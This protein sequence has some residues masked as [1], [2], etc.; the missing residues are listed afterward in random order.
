[1]SVNAINS[2]TTASTNSTRNTSGVLGKDEFL[3]LL[4]T[5]LRY[6]DPLNPTDNTEYVSQLAEFSALEQMSNM[7]SGISSMQALSMNGKWVTATV[8]DSSSGEETEIEGVVDS[9][10]VKNGQAT[11]IVNG[12]EVELENVTNVQDYNRASVSNLSS[13]INKT[14]EGYIY[15]SD[16]LQ[17]LSVKGTVSG[18]EKGIYEDYA[19]MDGVKSEVSSILSDD[20]DDS[21]DMLEYLEAHIGEEIEIE[22]TDSDTGKK[23]P[24]TAVLESVSETDDAITVTL[25]GVLV[26]VDGIYNVK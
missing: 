17:L 7:S 13:L 12:T 19:V 10:K 6:Q 8:T 16:S 26:P 15:D 24:V 14:C 5:Q 9:V 4:V 3:N 25:N 21:E 11:L 1:M 23:V 18:I 20:Y 22:L 2:Y